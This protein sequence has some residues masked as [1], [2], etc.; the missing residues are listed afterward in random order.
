MQFTNS[1]EMFNLGLAICSSMITILACGI[2]Y[3]GREIEEFGAKYLINFAITNFIFTLTYVIEILAGLSHNPVAYHIR[4]FANLGQFVLPHVMCLIMTL[5]IAFKIELTGRKVYWRQRICVIFVLNMI[6]FAIQIFHP[7]LYWY[8][9]EGIYHRGW[10]FLY[11]EIVGFFVE[12]VVLYIL[13]YFSSNLEKEVIISLTLNLVAPAIAMLISLYTDTIQLLVFATTISLFIMS[14]YLEVGQIGRYIEGEREMELLNSRVLNTQLRPHFLYNALS[15]ISQLCK[16]NPQVASEMTDRFS[17]YL[18]KNM[19]DIQA[20][21]PVPFQKELEYIENYIAIEKMRFGED[22]QVAYDIKTTDFYVPPLVIQPLIENSIKH[23]LGGREEGGLIVI[24]TDTFEGGHI[25]KI[26][27]DG[28]GFDTEKE[29]AAA[30][31]GRVHVG[32]ESVKN[33][34]REIPHSKLIIKSTVGKGTTAMIIIPLQYTLK[35]KEL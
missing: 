15:S 28:V 12:L 10:F 27:D 26:A 29:N 23:G 4:Y 30:N 7:I 35:N 2:I 31:D 34:L 1:Y 17:E 25:I 21:K 22:L 6:P 20:A 5:Y 33:R 13:Y 24:S 32:M 11:E 18:S 8:D 3:M 9:Q 16:Q 14:L 19:R